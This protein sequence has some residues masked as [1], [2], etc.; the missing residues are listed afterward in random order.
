MEIQLHLVNAI[1]KHLDTHY[2]E[3]IESDEAFRMLRERYE[4]FKELQEKQIN[5][6]APASPIIPKY[7]EA[8]LELV[9]VRRKALAEIKEENKY[10]DEIIKNIEK[11]IDHEEARLRVQLKTEN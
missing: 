9:E 2:S 8:V 10:P 7:F 6:K 5:K 1:L 11:G 3:E 4:H